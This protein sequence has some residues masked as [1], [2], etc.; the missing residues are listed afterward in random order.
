[1]KLFS[2]LKKSKKVAKPTDI[3]KANEKPHSGKKPKEQQLVKIWKPRPTLVER[4][5]PNDEIIVSKT[6]TRGNITYGNKI[7]I[8]MSG[9]SPE[10]LMGQPH[11]IVRHPDMPQIIFKALWD[12]VSK[13]KEINAYVIN[14]A[15]DGSYYWVYANVTP[16]FDVK[17]NIIGY[18]SVRRRP[19]KKAIEIIEPFYKVLRKAENIGG[20][21]ESTKELVKL[22]DSKKMEYEELI[23]HLQ[24]ML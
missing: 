22:L 12:T 20:I 14:L 21:H 24:Y 11:S 7:F 13:G 4:S 1:M 2:F 10:E 16:S 9:Y 18:H 23:Y 17:R 5:F 19:N 6:D 8:K 3:K 15:K